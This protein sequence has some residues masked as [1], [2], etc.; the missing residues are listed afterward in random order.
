MGIIFITVLSIGVFTLSFASDCKIYYVKPTDD[1]QTECP[2]QP[3]INCTCLTLYEYAR[4]DERFFP[5]GSNATLSFLAGNHS[6]NTTLTIN[7]ASKFQVQSLRSRIHL[8]NDAE[9]QFLGDSASITGLDFRHLRYNATSKSSNILVFCNYY[10]PSSLT[11][12][13]TSFTNVFIELFFANLTILG[14]VIFDY[15]YDSDLGIIIG[16][17]CNLEIKSDAV[18]TFDGRGSSGGLD[19]QT[20]NAT[21]SGHVEFHNSIAQ[22]GGSIDMF[23]SP[24][25]NCT[26]KVDHEGILYFYNSVARHHGGVMYLENV[27]IQLQGKIYLESNSATESGGAIYLYSSFL[28]FW[29]TALL[30][31]SNNH[32]G[33]F[34]GAIYVFDT[35]PYSYCLAHKLVHT[36]NCF[37]QVVGRNVSQK[38]DVQMVF[39]NNTANL[40]GDTIYGGAIDNCTLTGLNDSGVKFNELTNISKD[41]LSISSQPF[42]LCPCGLGKSFL[43]TIHAFPGEKFAVSVVTF[44]QRDGVAQSIIQAYLISNGKFNA[45]LSLANAEGNRQ[46]SKGCTDLNYTILTKVESKAV[47]CTFT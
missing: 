13:D 12:I 33:R 4:D 18:V 43:H 5:S 24:Y 47:S 9:I 30:T 36:E 17:V 31:I 16:F 3:N 14:N 19:L 27:N 6:L 40:G 15:S 7:S 29:P 46:S 21:I 23:C 41:N 26:I 44:G 10:C 11:L 45:D 38:L 37:F 39:K 34:G 8:T 2:K 20:C 32:A 1:S 35:N 25:D 42:K 22:N 28:Y